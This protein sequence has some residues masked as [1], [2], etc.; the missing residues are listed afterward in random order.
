MYVFLFAP[1][2]FRGDNDHPV[3]II[4]LCCSNSI[5]PIRIDS[6]LFGVLLQGSAFEGAV[7]A[8]RHVQAGLLVVE[9]GPNEQG[10]GNDPRHERDVAGEKG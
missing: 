5:Q 7:Y 3:R 9:N 4:Q 2:F 8:A 10:H 1:V 6:I